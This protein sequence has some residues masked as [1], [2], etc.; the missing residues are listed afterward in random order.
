MKFH[1]KKVL[2]IHNFENSTMDKFISTMFNVHSDN[3][4]YVFEL[5]GKTAQRLVFR[6]SDFSSA[7]YPNV[8]NVNKFQKKSNHRNL[9][10]SSSN[11]RPV[12]VKSEETSAEIRREKY[13][14]EVGFDD[15]DE[16]MRKIVEENV[17]SER[18]FVS[19][20]NDLNT[21][22]EEEYQERQQQKQEVVSK[23]EED[24]WAEIGLI[25]WQGSMVNSKDELPQK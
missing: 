21:N 23:E 5:P 13:L 15:H 1:I 7:I 4:S 24:N 10:A 19:F 20:V 14:F 25:G 11:R 12:K 2:N 22:M 6:R 9:Q 17:R 8:T 18:D 16:S 3:P